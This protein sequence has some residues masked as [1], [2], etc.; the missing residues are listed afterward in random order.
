V[1]KPGREDNILKRERE[2]YL[3]STT[4]AYK[5]ISCREIKPIFQMAISVV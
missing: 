2:K 5:P 3:S 4:Q 1:V